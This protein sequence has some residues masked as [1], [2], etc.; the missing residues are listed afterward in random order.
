M[1]TGVVEELLLYEKHMDNKLY[2]VTVALKEW[3]AN[4]SFVNNKIIVI[5]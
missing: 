2:T 4:T 1:C 3:Y 5:I